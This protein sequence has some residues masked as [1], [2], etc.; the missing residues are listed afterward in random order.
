MVVVGGGMCEIVLGLEWFM[1][2]VWNMRDDV[3]EMVWV[4]W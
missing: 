4:G 2:Y 1:G 3:V